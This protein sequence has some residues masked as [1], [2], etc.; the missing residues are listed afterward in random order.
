MG[1]RTVNEEIILPDRAQRIGLNFI[2]G[3]YY[4]GK[5]TID[6]PELVT[7]GAFP[8][9]ELTGSIKMQ[10]RGMVAK[11]MSSPTQYAFKM[12]VHALEASILNYELR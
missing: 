2:Q 8:V 6:E 12:Q 4:Q 10:S 5:I 1:L 3:K 9:Y 7:T 11:I